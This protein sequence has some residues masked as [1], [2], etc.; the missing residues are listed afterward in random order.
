MKK[1]SWSAFFAGV[2]TDIGMQVIQLIIVA[3]VY[4]FLRSPL[5]AYIWYIG[6][7]I[8][9][10]VFVGY[11][12]GNVAKEDPLLNALFYYIVTYVLMFVFVSMVAEENWTHIPSFWAMVVQTIELFGLSV[13]ALLVKK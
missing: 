7:E 4:V 12:I 6:S 13:G 5:L 1:I 10:S 3:I 11:V 8:I 9:V 2:F